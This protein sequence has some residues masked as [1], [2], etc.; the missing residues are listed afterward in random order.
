LLEE[1]KSDVD[2]APVMKMVRGDN[3]H[4]CADDA[5]LLKKRPALKDL[6]AKY[7]ATNEKATAGIPAPRPAPASS[8]SA[9]SA[10]ASATPASTSSTPAPAASAAP[11]PQK[12]GGCSSCSVTNGSAGLATAWPLVGLALLS[13]R[14]RS[15]RASKSLL[16][17]R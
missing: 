10:S 6:V 1:G 4:A 17:S 3:Y 15:S 11:A 8:A 7:K 9:P 5:A 16:R 13:L 12:G 2:G 14:R